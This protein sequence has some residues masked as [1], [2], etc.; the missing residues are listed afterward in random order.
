MAV[1]NP[2]LDVYTDADLKAE[3]E[4]R[5][6][7]KGAGARPAIRPAAFL[8]PAIQSM[9]EENMEQVAADGHEAKDVKHYLWEMAMEELYGPKVWDWYNKRLS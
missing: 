9:L 2:I 6:E 5:A 4:R 3:L 8:S 1:R 7:L